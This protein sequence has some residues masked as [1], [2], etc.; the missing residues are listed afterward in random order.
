ML[1]D[2]FKLTLGVCI[3]LSK[4]LGRTLVC[5]FSAVALFALLE[6]DLLFLALLLYF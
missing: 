1:E 4:G 2:S 5:V 3:S 6:I